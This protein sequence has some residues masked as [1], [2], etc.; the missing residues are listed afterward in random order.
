MRSNDIIYSSQPIRGTVITRLSRPIS[1]SF[2]PFSRDRFT[3]WIWNNLSK[4]IR[5]LS[6]LSPPSFSRCAIENRSIVEIR[7]PSRS[8]TKNSSCGRVSEIFEFLPF[9]LENFRT[10]F[11]N[12]RLEK[13][14]KNR[15]DGNYTCH[16]SRSFSEEEEE[17]L[18]SAHSVPV[19][20]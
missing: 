11:G 4:Q 1:N 16:I 20:N 17:R 14:S 6:P 9:D 15:R 13:A 18:V 8:F 3:K 10:N 19:A 5:S 7:F 12:V 2:L